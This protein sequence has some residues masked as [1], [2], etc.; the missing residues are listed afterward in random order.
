MASTA[1]SLALSCGGS[2]ALIGSAVA[3][4]ERLSKMLASDI[5][6]IGLPGTVMASF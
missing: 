3:L 4:R 5:T 1:D 6:P 2:V